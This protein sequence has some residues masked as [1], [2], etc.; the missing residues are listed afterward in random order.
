MYELIIVEDNL[1]AKSELCRIRFAHVQLLANP[2]QILSNTIHLNFLHDAG[3][4]F[5]EFEY[6]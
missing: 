2:A 1:Y 6:Y 5:F 4:N 3:G